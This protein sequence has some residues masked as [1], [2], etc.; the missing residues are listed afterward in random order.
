MVQTDISQL[1]RECGDW[2]DTLRSLRDQLIGCQ[3]QL[4]T[5]ASRSLSKEQ[6]T[7]VEHFHNQFHIQ[8]INIHDLKQ[9][10]K[11][12]ERRM[13]FETTAHEGQLTEETV[14]DH[15]SLF[16]QYEHLTSSLKDLTQEFTDFTHRSK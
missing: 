8:L 1:S 2:R 13:K 7:A 15:E 12:H 3:S 6:L 16:G 11:A 5:F 9:A 4:Q 14:G 10:V